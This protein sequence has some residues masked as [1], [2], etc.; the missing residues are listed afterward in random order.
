MA[1]A[2]IKNGDAYNHGANHREFMIASSADLSGIKEAYPNCAVGSV[3]YTSDFSF[4][5]VKDV[6]GT[7]NPDPTED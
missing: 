1:Y 2:V 7:W 6:D 4:I 3:A 5:S